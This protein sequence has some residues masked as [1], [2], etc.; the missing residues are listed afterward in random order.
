LLNFLTNSTQ[1]AG[2]GYVNI[3]DCWQIKT[4]R[5]ANTSRLIPDPDRFPDGIIGTA[6]KIHD[7]DLK[8]GIYSSAGTKVS[9]VLSSCFKSLGPS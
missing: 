6:K 1:D 2:Y 9:T 5:D 8:I 3:D 7:L 4:H